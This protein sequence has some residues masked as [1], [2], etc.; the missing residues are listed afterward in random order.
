MTLSAL[1]SYGL[2][3]LNTGQK[4]EAVSILEHCLSVYKEHYVERSPDIIPIM[5]NLALGYYRVE[6]FDQAISLM[7]QALSIVG[8]LHGPASVESILPLTNLG[9][10][11]RRNGDHAG[12]KDCYQRALT[13]S[14]TYLGRRHPFSLLAYYNLGIVYFFEEQY[15]EYLTIARYVFI[16]RL[17]Q[18]GIGHTDTLTILQWLC[19]QCHLHTTLRQAAEE[20]LSL[21]ANDSH[22]GEVLQQLL[23]FREQLNATSSE[24]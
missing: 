1:N 23:T 18:L 22:A 20:F 16:E 21:A 5:L 7:R 12:A 13:L 4:K 14:S 9:A 2:M 10:M 17:R 24:D 11:L 19:S 3:I 15:E 8:Q 6:A